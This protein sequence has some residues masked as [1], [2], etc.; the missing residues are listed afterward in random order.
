MTDIHELFCANLKILRERRGF[1]QEKMSEKLDI[2]VRSYQKIEYGYKTRTHWPTPERI[3]ELAKILK[4]DTV[5]FFKPVKK[6]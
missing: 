1:T 2:G 6:S 3:K 4:C 5:E